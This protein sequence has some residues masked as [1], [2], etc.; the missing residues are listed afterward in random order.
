MR[1][2]P[3][4]LWNVQTKC[5]LEHIGAS[6]EYI[7]SLIDETLR[8]SK[9]YKIKELEMKHNIEMDDINKSEVIDGEYI[10]IDYIK[11]DNPRSK[12]ILLDRLEYGKRKYLK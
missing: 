6:I 12:E 2:S 11:E 7:S 10:P 3:E 8:K 4:F 1:F 5:G 9:M